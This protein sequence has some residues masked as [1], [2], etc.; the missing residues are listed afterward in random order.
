MFIHGGT[1]KE[2][3]ASGGSTRLGITDDEP[4]FSSGATTRLGGMSEEP[5][6]SC[7]STRLGASGA[8]GETGLGQR[9][10]RSL[11]WREMGGLFIGKSPRTSGGPYE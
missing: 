11:K 3:G 4:G 1:C 5:G 7:C 6:S 9:R 2:S 10:R 8:W